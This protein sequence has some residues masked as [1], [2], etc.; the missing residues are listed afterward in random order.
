MQIK[1]AVI[2]RHLHHLLANDETL[3]TPAIRNQGGDATHPQLVL[4]LERGELWEPGHRAIGVHDFA[5]HR[6]RLESGH[7]R[8]IHARLRVPGTPKHSAL[9][10]P[11]RKD[12]TRLDQLRR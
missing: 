2:R 10:R 7:P 8:E 11:Q 5:N 12:V 6:R 9:F 1:R 3:A 4:F